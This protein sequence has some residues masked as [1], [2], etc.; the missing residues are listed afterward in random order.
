MKYTLIL[1]LL[2]AL[3]TACSPRY[4]G[5][6][7]YV[8]REQTGEELPTERKV[9]REAWLD[10]RV[11]EP[12]TTISRLTALAE[13][14]GGYPAATNSTSTTLRIPDDR[15]EQAMT[16]TATYGKVRD[17]RLSVTDVTDGYRD[18]G[19]R[20]DNA[21]RARQRYLELLDRATTVTEAI[22]VE[23][24]L[25]RLSETIDLLRGR[26]NALNQREAL[27]TLTVGVEKRERPGPLG[28]VFLGLWRGVS[29]LFV[30]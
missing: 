17:R 13:R 29:W 26:R 9:V 15:L 27:A 22:E 5:T 6:E 3:L 18:L 10:L 24:E 14:L 1:S 11:D 20:L 2:L 4:A 30:R 16:E 7:P 21:E 8:A 12:D 19:I 23:R 28:Y 25:E